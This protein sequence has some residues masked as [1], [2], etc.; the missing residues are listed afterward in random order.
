[1]NG[2]TIM[3]SLALASP[4][5]T[6]Q[7]QPVPKSALLGEMA[8]VRPEPKSERTWTPLAIIGTGLALIAG[9]LLGMKL[10][11]GCQTRDAGFRC[12]D[13]RGGSP[14][15]PSVVVLGL[16]LT[17]TGEHWRRTTEPREP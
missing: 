11:T 3:L 15:F 6:P 10:Q 12:T 7:T 17:I 16:A 1:M 4:V 8:P 13:P 5:L 9:G 2:L 14:I